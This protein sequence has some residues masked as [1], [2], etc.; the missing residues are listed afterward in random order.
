MKRFQLAI[1]STTCAFAVGAAFAATSTGGI[2]PIVD[3]QS[4]YLLGGSKNG[5][6]INAK[7]TAKALKGGEQYTVYGKNSRTGATTGSK[8]RT[9]EAPCEDTHWVTL[10]KNFNGELAVGPGSNAT[11]RKVTPLG[12]NQNFYRNEVAKILKANKIKKPKVVI[13][14]LWR[15]DL[16]GDKVDEVL[17]SATRYANP[18]NDLPMPNRVSPNASAG[19]YSLVLLRKVVNGKVKTITL[20]EEIYATK[21][22]FNA[23]N[24]NRLLG[25]YD[26]NGDGKM[27]VVLDGRYYEGDW[28]TVVEVKGG[29]AKEVLSEGCGA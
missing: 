10:K 17:L 27:E 2:R 16:D 13:T 15:V 18:D 20:A 9:N 5:K 28:R 1:F 23:P 4:G 26:L 6:W 3:V 12:L 14:Q 25:V 29:Q 22:V 24:I 7:E 21:K 11:P 8:S 19:D